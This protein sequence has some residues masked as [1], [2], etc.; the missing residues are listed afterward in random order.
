MKR[1]TVVMALFSVS[2]LAVWVIFQ[3]FAASP[4]KTKSDNTPIKVHDATDEILKAIQ[5]EDVAVPVTGTDVKIAPVFDATGAI[6]SDP[7]GT[8]WSASHP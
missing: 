5:S 4:P 2:I 6:V 1:F 7:T 3:A 8:I